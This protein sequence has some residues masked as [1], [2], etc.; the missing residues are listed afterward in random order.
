MTIIENRVSKAS[1]AHKLQYLKLQFWWQTQY[2]HHVQHKTRWS[3]TMNCR[4]ALKCRL[5][6]V[7]IRPETDEEMPPSVLISSH[8]EHEL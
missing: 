2:K 7:K 8:C 3:S 1:N 4:S 6:F 5:S